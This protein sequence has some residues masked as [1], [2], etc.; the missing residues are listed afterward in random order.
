MA[1]RRALTAFVLV[2]V[3]IQMG[4][5]IGVL[6]RGGSYRPDVHIAFSVVG[7]CAG[8][9]CALLALAFPRLF[10]RGKK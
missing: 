1:F 2:N 6:V 3:G 10:R 9:V 8:L 4:V 7:L 5:G